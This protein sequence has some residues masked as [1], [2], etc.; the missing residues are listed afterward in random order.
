[1]VLIIRS[2]QYKISK[3]KV[4][5]IFQPVME[6][7]PTLR[8]VTT[9][10]P[11]INQLS[12]KF[13]P[14]FNIDISTSNLVDFWLNCGWEV[15]FWL[16]IVTHVQNQQF[17]NQKSTLRMVKESWGS[18]LN[19]CWFNVEKMMCPLGLMIIGMQGCQLLKIA[20]HEKPNKV[21]F[22]TCQIVQFWLTKKK[23]QAKK[24][25]KKKGT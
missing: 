9:Y 17:L 19:Q 8:H 20:W 4:F 12:T 3:N 5:V 25:K 2:Y 7:V 13:Q 23:W 11:K 22:C 14:F 15:V 6:K 16:I 18:T 24:K 1:M 21:V 10:Q